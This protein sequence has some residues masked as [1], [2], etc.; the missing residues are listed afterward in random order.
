[1]G[2]RIVGKNDA[3]NLR[4]IPESHSCSNCDNYDHDYGWCEEYEFSVYAAAEKVC[5][6]WK[7]P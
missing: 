7:S 3:P 6:D 2:G 5:D 4:E 1:M